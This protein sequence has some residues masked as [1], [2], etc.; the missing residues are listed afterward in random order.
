[1]DGGQGLVEIAVLPGIDRIDAQGWDACAAP[2]T[3]DGG[4]AAAPFVTHR[5]LLALEQSDSAV[6]SAGWAP[7]HLVASVDGRIVGVMPLYL[8]GHSQGEYVFDHVWAHASERAGGEYYPKL[9][10]AVPFTPATAP[11]LL[12]RPGGALDADTFRAALLQGAVKLTEQND[13][14]SLHI[15]FCTER[16]WDLGGTLGLLQRTDQQFHW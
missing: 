3:A 9:Q 15:T 14:S 1:M 5:F 7:R 6:A 2:E 10:S 16:E 11:R 4:R 13:L 12:A 8:K